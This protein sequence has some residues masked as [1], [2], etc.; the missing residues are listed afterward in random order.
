MSRDIDALI[1]PFCSLDAWASAPTTS[2]GERLIWSMQCS[3]TAVTDSHMPLFLN[4]PEIRIIGLSDT[5]ITNQALPLL[6]RLPHLDCLDIDG[7]VIDDAAIE[8]L[9]AFPRL[10]VLHA[11]RTKLTNAGVRELRRRLPNCEIVS[12]FDE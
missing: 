8:A 7:T 11:S 3:G 2:D 5:A 4:M 12:D 9:S 1:A 10:T 6:A